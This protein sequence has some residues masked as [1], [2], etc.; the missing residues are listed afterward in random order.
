MADSNCTAINVDPIDIQTQLGGGYNNHCRKSLINFKET[1][2]FNI[3]QIDR[4]Y[5]HIDKRLAAVGADIQRLE[6]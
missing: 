4:G 6:A 3:R 5:E 1:N 2:I